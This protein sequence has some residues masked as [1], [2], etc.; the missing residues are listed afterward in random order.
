MPALFAFVG[1][2]QEETHRFAITYHRELRGKN[3]RRSELDS[4][5][6]VGE[7]RRETLLKTFKSIKAIRAASYEEL[8]AVVPK[9]TARAVY[10]H[11]HAK[12]EK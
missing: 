5:E 2:I 1:R 7:K 9:N 6:G 3:Q 10:D 12:E 8:A 4:I 11:F